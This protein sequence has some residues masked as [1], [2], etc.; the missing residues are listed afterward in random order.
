MTS[1]GLAAK[2]VGALT[3]TL[4]STIVKCSE[5]WCPSNLHAQVP[6]VDGVPNTETK[7]RSGSRENVSPVS[8]DS[9]IASSSM[10]WV[11]VMYPL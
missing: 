10:I 11:A 5:R 7:Y 9:R 3:V 6:S 1:A 2:K 4:P 8:S